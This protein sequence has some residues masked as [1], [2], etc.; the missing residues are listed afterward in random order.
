VVTLSGTRVYPGVYASLLVFVE[1][2]ASLLPGM[3]PY[4]R[5]TVGQCTVRCAHLSRNEQKE[6]VL[7]DMRRLPEKPPFTRFTVGHTSQYASH[8]HG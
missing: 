6:G 8:N 4:T 2:Y 5:F 1:G 7:R 3:P